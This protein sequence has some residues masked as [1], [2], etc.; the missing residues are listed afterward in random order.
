MKPLLQILVASAFG[1]VVAVGAIRGEA[2]LITIDTDDGQGADARIRGG[3]N[4]GMNFGADNFVGIRFAPA[5]ANQLTNSRKTYLRFDLSALGV[6]AASVQ[7]QLTST[8]D[9][10]IPVG[11]V[12]FDLYGLNNLDAGESWAEGSITW[13]NAPQNNTA[14]PNGFLG[15]A[16]LLGS[17][18]FASIADGDTLTFS[19]PSMAAFINADTNN[20]VTFML[21]SQLVNPTNN[22]TFASKEN[23]ESP[24]PTLLITPVPEPSSLALLGLGFCGL[25]GF[26]KRKKLQ[27]QQRGPRH[28]R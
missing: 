8:N 4:A 10:T 13:N 27:A 1:L 24:H 16:T 12:T 28:P 18:T 14:S 15:G 26:N 19:F 6:T 23:T 11:G 20:L 22:Y 7:L 21:A 3:A 9:F 2:A 17:T 25:V 5:G